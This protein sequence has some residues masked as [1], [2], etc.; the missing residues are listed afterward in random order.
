MQR[1][2]VC[3]IYAVRVPSVTNRT[4]YDN[5]DDDDDDD[6]KRSGYFHGQ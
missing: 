6:R 3:R 1:S 2:K 4:W 5:D